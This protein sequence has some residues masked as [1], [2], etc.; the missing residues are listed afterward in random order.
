MEAV[1]QLTGG[2][3]HDFNNLL[4]VITGNLDLLAR[5]VAG[6]ERLERL[7]A[8]AQKGATRGAQLTSQLLAF[9]RRQT[10]RPENRSI[11]AMVREFDVLATRMLGGAIEVEFVLASDTG[12]CSVDPAQFGSALLNLVV[13]ARDAMASGGRLVIRTHNLT[14]DERAAAHHSGTRPGEYVVVAVIDSGSGMTADVLERATEP[15]YTTKPLGQ[16][17]GLGL[18]QVYGFVR[19]S[20]GFLEIDSTPGTGTT[21]RMH[22][23]RV[24]ATASASRRRAAMCHGSG[25]ILVVE[26]DPLVRELVTAQLED[27]GYATLSAASGPEALQVLGGATPPPIDL[28]LTDMVMPGGMSGTELVGEARARRPGLRVVL[29]SGYV[30]GAGPI[31]GD[32]LSD[33]PM[34]SKPYRQTDLARIIEQALEKG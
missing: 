17:T 31:A 5:A 8:T 34:L 20:E 12:A 27:L 19:Q 1:G 33:V 18:S 30:A 22:L 23:P 16:G 32:S 15:F 29:T 26:D 13:N 9:A 6:D 24:A 14:L 7:V 10:L 21:V 2:I 11:N 3:A 28:M 25:T 4:L